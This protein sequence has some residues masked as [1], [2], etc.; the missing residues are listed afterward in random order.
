MK[1]FFKFSIIDP[2]VG[3]GEWRALSQNSIMASMVRALNYLIKIV[4]GST[5]DLITA[6]G[7]ADRAERK[8]KFIYMSLLSSHAPERTSRYVRSLPTNK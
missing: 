3:G 5:K 7:T 1:Y 8:C 2:E 4:R 6:Y